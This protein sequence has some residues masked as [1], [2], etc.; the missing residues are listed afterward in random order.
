MVLGGKLPHIA[1]PHGNVSLTLPKNSGRPSFGDRL[2]RMPTGSCSAICGHTAF[3]ETAEAEEVLVSY[4]STMAH[5]GHWSD[6][7]F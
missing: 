5:W 7:Q 6:S 1:R 3:T 2:G 4:A